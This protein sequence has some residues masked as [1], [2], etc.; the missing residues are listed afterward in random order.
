MATTIL[1]NDQDQSAMDLFS[2]MDLNCPPTTA[3]PNF[4]RT[5]FIKIPE[6]ELTNSTLPLIQLPPKYKILKTF[7]KTKAQKADLMIAFDKLNARYG[8]GTVKL[9]VLGSSQKWQM[10][11]THRSNRYTTLWSE[12]LRVG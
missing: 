12:L 11:A 7:T 9:A 3:L 2:G 8:R 1:T 4:S 10:K 5:K 6:K